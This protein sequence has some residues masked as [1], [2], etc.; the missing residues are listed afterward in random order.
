MPVSAITAAVPNV[1]LAQLCGLEYTGKARDHG[2]GVHLQRGVV[3]HHLPTKLLIPA[4]G[5]RDVHAP[6]RHRVLLCQWQMEI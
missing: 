5:G 6:L 1:Q 3:V 2:S 4:G